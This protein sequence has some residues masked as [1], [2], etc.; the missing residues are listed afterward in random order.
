MSIYKGPQPREW[1]LEAL[2]AWE[3]QHKGIIQAV[4]G[5]GKTILAVNAIAKKLE[6]KG[7]DWI[8]K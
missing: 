8:N 1:Q 7:Y 2:S 5:S 3:K 4:P 6:E